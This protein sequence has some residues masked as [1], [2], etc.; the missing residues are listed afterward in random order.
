MSRAS[1]VKNFVGHVTA[2]FSSVESIQNYW[3][4]TLK[5]NSKG[6]AVIIELDGTTWFLDNQKLLQG[7]TK[8]YNKGKC[9]ELITNGVASNNQF[10]VHVALIGGIEV[11]GK[12][13]RGQNIYKGKDTRTPQQKE[14]FECVITL[15][16]QWLKDN[17]RDVNKDLGFVG[18][19]DFSKDSNNDGIISS[20]ER[21]KDCPC[22]DMIIEFRKYAS[23]DR[24]GLL[25]TVTKINATTATANNFVIHSIVS[26][27]S[28]S[29][30]ATIYKTSVQRI[31]SDNQLTSDMIKVG[32]KLKIYR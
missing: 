27:D 7:Y 21:I 14:A 31:K 8:T 26:G 19:R 4:N 25:P 3:R 1:S 11:V 30:I 6:Y 9:F 22:F 32:Q 5:W 17:G 28:L 12:D 18:H 20:W 2:G 23:E 15:F 24:K 10:N 16:L 13:S 29:K